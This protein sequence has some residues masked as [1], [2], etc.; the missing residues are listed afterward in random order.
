ML[1]DENA[2]HAL[3]VLAAHG[4]SDKSWL[5]RAPRPYVVVNKTTA[6]IPNTGLD[7][8]SYAWWIVQNY[9][10]LPSWT[11]F[12]HHHEYDWHHPYYSQLVSMAIDVD[13]LAATHG[14]RYLNVAHDRYGRLTLY[15]KPALRELSRAENQRLCNELL[16]AYTVDYTGNVTY[17]PGAQFWVH[18][19]RIL[20][21]PLSFYQHLYRALTDDDH[22][23]LSRSS[24]FYEGRSL[25]V[26]F[27]EAYWHTIFGEGTNLHSVLNNYHELPIVSPLRWPSFQR[28][29]SC[30]TPHKWALR[31]GCSGQKESGPVRVGSPRQRGLNWT[32]DDVLK[33]VRRRPPTVT[34]PVSRPVDMQAGP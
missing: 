21:R 9:R 25:H 17:A 5:A 8:S 6:G 13:A 11:L 19:D 30:D 33:A 15:T 23:L 4:P 16:G 18:R 2:S 32:R 1:A 22:P 24:I 34:P 12:M 27:A 3:V 28:R 7:A 29:L 20:A 14:L 26:F 10:E 31:K